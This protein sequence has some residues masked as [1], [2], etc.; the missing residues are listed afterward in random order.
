[1]TRRGS[2]PRPREGWRLRAT[3][4][5]A[6]R[7]EGRHPLRRRRVRVRPGRGG[8][9]RRAG[10]VRRDR[11]LAPRRGR[12]GDQR[13]PGRP[14][15]RRGARPAHGPRGRAPAPDE[16]A[17]VRSADGAISRMSSRAV[18][19]TH[20]APGADHRVRGSVR[21]VRPVAPRRYRQM[22]GSGLPA[23]C[24]TGPRHAIV[25]LRVPPQ[26]SVMFRT[27]VTPCPPAR[28]SPVAPDDHLPCQ[29][30]PLPR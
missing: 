4:W 7:D 22:H 16:G 12:R 9:G 25:V 1:M 19:R 21:S 28:R 29:A 20:T 6:S 30:R 8:T 11:S 23:A 2:R 27:T 18:G 14:A 17:A 5:R 10:T 24:P 3:R 13:G 15:T 26:R